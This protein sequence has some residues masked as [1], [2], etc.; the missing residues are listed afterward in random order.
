MNTRPLFAALALSAV[1]F[2]APAAQAGENPCYSVGPG[3]MQ[4][5]PISDRSREDVIA[6]M[7][8]KSASTDPCY[9]V[10]PG[11]MQCRAVSNRSRAD[12]VAELQAAQA[13]GDVVA[14]GEAPQAFAK[15][16]VSRP[17]QAHYAQ[18]R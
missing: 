10:G 4:C 1:A 7:K 16:P 13:E 2:A 14:V 8:Q 17:V 18:A 6:G 15:A 9:S 3:V 5:R 11:V 12:V